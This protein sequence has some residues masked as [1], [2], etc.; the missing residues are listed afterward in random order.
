MK[1][2]EEMEEK[3]GVDGEWRKNGERKREG[4]GWR[5]RVLK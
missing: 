1:W 3:K 4:K 5:E 2:K